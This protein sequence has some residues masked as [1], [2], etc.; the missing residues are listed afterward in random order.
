MPETS[1]DFVSVALK[2]LGGLAIFLYGVNLMGD[3]LK[4]LAAKRMK[5]IM[6]RFT[7]NFF[8][9]VVTGTVATAILDSSSCVIIMVLSMVHAGIITSIESYGVIMGANIGTTV[10]SQII[11]LDVM[12]YSPVF[13]AIGLTIMMAGKSE[14]AKKAG[15]LVFA[16]G[17]VFFGLFFMDTAV[18]PLKSYPPIT[19]W[20]RGLDNPIKGALLGALVT[21]IVQSS[22]ATVGIAIVLASQGLIS[23]PAGV[24]IMLGA[25]IGTCSDTLLA[26]IGKSR[27][28]IRAGLFHLFFN[29]IT[30]TIGLILIHPLVN[31]VNYISGSAAPGTRIANAHMIFNITGVLVLV[32]FIPQ[33]HRFLKKLVPGKKDMEMPALEAGV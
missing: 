16:A 33:F 4:E 30:V 18:A 25:E 29:I 22:S 31:L 7:K 21:L 23:F 15:R 28:A 1:V 3:T 19:E 9:G 5:S 10:S 12:E 13:L 11:A 17:L 24:A 2:M 8:S 6:K 20:M 27:Q 14:T 32:W 26:V